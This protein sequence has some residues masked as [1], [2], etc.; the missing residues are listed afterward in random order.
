MLARDAATGRP[1]GALTV[2]A[3][4]TAIYGAPPFGADYPGHLQAQLRRELGEPGFISLFAEGCAGD[5]NH[6]NIGSGE[7]QDGETYPPRVGARLA[8]TIA[9]SLPL[10]RPIRDGQLAMRSATI[11]SPVAPI[12]EREYAEA[13]ARA[14]GARPGRAAV[15]RRGGRLAEGV[16]PQ[17][18]A[19]STAGGCPRRSRPSAST[20]TRPS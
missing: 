2:F 1:L 20:A 17:V 7:P 3:M 15:P 6:V 16:P 10:D 9:R 8:A 18:L 13:Q 4:H 5:V 19:E 11:R 12:D 14:R